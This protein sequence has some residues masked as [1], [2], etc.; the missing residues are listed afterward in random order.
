MLVKFSSPGLTSISLCLVRPCCFWPRQTHYHHHFLTTGRHVSRSFNLW[1]LQALGQV[2]IVTWSP[3][4]DEPCDHVTWHSAKHVSRS[5][6]LWA[7]F[8]CQGKS[9]SYLIPTYF[10]TTCLL[11]ACLDD[12]SLDNTS[13]EDVSLDNVSLGSVSLNDWSSLFPG[14]PIL[15]LLSIFGL[16]SCSEDIRRL[17]YIMA[18]KS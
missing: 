4:I 13:L 1:V 14:W 6:S 11:T 9:I 5:S 7:A 17:W 12:V 2:D 15:S 8:G 3:S 16:L 18:R 10:L